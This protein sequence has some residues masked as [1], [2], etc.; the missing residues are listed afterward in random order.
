MERFQGLRDKAR[1]WYLNYD[2][3][4]EKKGFPIV[5]GVCVLVI[6][7]SAAFTFSQRAAL[8]NP[9]FPESTESVQSA[10]NA[11]QQSL[12]EALVASRATLGP[13][14]TPTRV[15]FQ[16]PVSGATTRTFS[17]AQPVWF[18][19][20]GCYQPHPAV[21]WEAEHGAPV[22]AC[23]SGTVIAVDETGLYGLRVCI[24]HADGYETRYLGLSEAPYVRVG[25]PVRAGQT[26]GHVGNGVLAEADAPAH[27][28]LEVLHDGQFVDPLPLIFSEGVVR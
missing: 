7:L 9:A 24:R 13:T 17:L 14:P 10:L 28:H 16:R 18:A 12:E 4:I 3:F 11:Q 23:Q 8:E 5:L 6:A 20:I 1:Q 15:A 19:R 21:D 22:V 25:D 26:I 2:A 27:L